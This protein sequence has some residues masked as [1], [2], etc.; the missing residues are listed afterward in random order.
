MLLIAARRVSGM[1]RRTRWWARH[2]RHGDAR[3]PRDRIGQPATLVIPRT[4]AQVGLRLTGDV[5]EPAHLM[6]EVAPANAPTTP[7]L[8]VDAAPPGADSAPAM[9]TLPAYALSTGDYS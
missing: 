3:A 4:A 5:A 1:P 9:V 2:R 7:A 8:R 6:A